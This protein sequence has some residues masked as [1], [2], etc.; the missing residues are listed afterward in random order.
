MH[1]MFKEVKYLSKFIFSQLRNKRKKKS[2]LHYF[3][4]YDF[5]Q[6]NHLAANVANSDINKI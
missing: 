1:V 6:Y 3:L 4:L 5:S 2:N